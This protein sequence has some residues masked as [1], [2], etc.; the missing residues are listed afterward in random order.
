MCTAKFQL[1]H[2]LTTCTHLFCW[3][4]KQNKQKTQQSSQKKKIM[5]F[6]IPSSSSSFVVVVV[7]SKETA[8]EMAMCVQMMHTNQHACI[9]LAN[10]NFVWK[11]GFQF[12][13]WHSLCFQRFA[14]RHTCSTSRLPLFQSV[15]LNAKNGDCC[16]KQMAVKQMPTKKTEAALA[17]QDANNQQTNSTARHHCPSKAECFQKCKNSQQKEKRKTNKQIAEQDTTA[18]ARRGKGRILSLKHK[19]S[20]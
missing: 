10:Y 2:H 7:C 18:P 1:V 8:N 11:W 20:K 14:L 17:R 6:K 3:P 12:Q 4:P 15:L 19:L 16:L 5:P 13:A 9:A